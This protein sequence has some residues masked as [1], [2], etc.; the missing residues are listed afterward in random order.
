MR[1]CVHAVF[2]VLLAIALASSLSRTALA[3]VADAQSDVQQKVK[4][5]EESCI[6]NLRSI[7]VAEGTYWGGDPK[8]GFA[9]SL[10]ELGPKG[11]GLI[12]RALAIGRKDGYHFSFTPVSAE[13]GKPISRYTISAR[14][15]RRLVKD[16]RSFFT[17]E[18]GVI[19]ST[20]ENRAA[21]AADPP[22]H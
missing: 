11:E 4:T 2:A 7:N 16:Q 6:G 9:R 15:I 17:D 1:S 13:T 22:V 3:Q 21:T 19:R 5:Y 12:V 14:P 10:K 8:K 20:R 18:T